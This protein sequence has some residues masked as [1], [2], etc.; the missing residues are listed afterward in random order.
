MKPD[1]SWCSDVINTVA[2]YTILN[3][4]AGVRNKYNYV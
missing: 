2:R 4:D 1:T 3:V